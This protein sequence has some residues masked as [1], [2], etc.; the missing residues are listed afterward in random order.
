MRIDY[1]K[2]E[3]LEEAKAQRNKS[4][5]GYFII[6]GIFLV[7]TIA[8]FLWYSTLPYEDSKI[9]IVKTIQYVLLAI[10]I[11]VS[12]IYLNIKFRRVNKYYKKCLDISVGLV[13][14]SVGSFV[15][16]SESLQTKD[17]VDFKSIV[18]LEINKK[19]DVFLERKVLVFYE[20]PFPEFE[21][22]QNVKYT[23]QGNVLKYYEIIEEQGE[24]QW[25][26]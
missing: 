15:E 17:G 10:F 19:K 8:L 25:E 3:F 13:E 2:K 16:Y 7:C 6:V 9:G 11:F 23:T 12:G 18:F 1:F 5:M 4:L 14:T 24:Q 21:A 26:Q 20:K 22:G